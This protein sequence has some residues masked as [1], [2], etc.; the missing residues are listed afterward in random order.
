M[1]LKPKGLVRGP[2]LPQPISPKLKESQK[3]KKKLENCEKDASYK[4]KRGRSTSMA[5][6]RWS[7]VYK[8]SGLGN[9]TQSQTKEEKNHERKTHP[10]KTKRPKKEEKKQKNNVKSLIGPVRKGS[11]F[12]RR[13]K[14]NP[15]MTRPRR[16][17]NR[18]EKIRE[19]SEEHTLKCVLKSARITNGNLFELRNDPSKGREGMRSIEEKVAEAI[20]DA[21]GAGTVYEDAFP[22]N[23]C[24]KKG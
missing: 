13:E 1:R 6:H 11:C 14:E 5:T 18:F 12:T 9:V 3:E 21:R 4:Q 10:Q 24:Q 2:A 20:V 7:H 16:R 15:L 22:C 8:N 23:N 17:L 19:G